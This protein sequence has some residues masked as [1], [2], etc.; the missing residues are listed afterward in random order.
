MLSIPSAGPFVPSCGWQEGATHTMRKQLGFMQL[1]IIVGYSLFYALYLITFFGLFASVPAG[2]DFTACH[3]GQLIYFGASVISMYAVLA[4][5]R[6][7]GSSTL[8]L[9]R[10][11]F[12][13]ALI[14]LAAPLPACFILH[15]IG[16]WVP[17]LALYA[18]CACSGVFTCLGFVLW[19]DLM[20]R[21]YMGGSGFLHSIVFA[22]GGMVFVAC[23]LAGSQAV[24]GTLCLVFLLAS[25]FLAAFISKR[26]EAS[27]DLPVQGAVEHFKSAFHL[28]VL[29]CATTLPFGFA[30]IL[31]Y[32]RLGV[33]IVV[34]M[35]LAV[36][37]DFALNMLIGAHRVVPFM[38]TL[39]TCVAF[40]TVALLLFTMPSDPAKVV[41]LGIVVCAWFV[42]RTVNGS[43]LMNLAA[44]K[45]V[46]LQYC[47]GRGKLAGN[48]GF[49]LGL[50][51]GIVTVQLMPAHPAAGGYIA[52]AIVACMVLAALFLLPF[53]NESEAPGIR[54][55]V[56]VEKSDLEFPEEVDLARKCQ[57]LIDRYKL[58]PRESEVL[59]YIV[60]GRNARHVAERLCISESTAKTH[61]SN[62]YRKTNVHSQQEL[63]D[64]IEE[65]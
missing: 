34:I 20:V 14:A 50:A 21:G 23:M 41:A 25:A 56:P 47:V 43:S 19:D 53:D 44:S 22:V 24:I 55:L 39:R 61:I 54:T 7:R 29:T 37:I 5:F 12:L 2:M 45:K 38:G 16:A 3:M 27:R 15:D 58:S 52:L 11:S 48:I 63:L 17:L 1:S 18:A 4:W 64:I 49:I 60:K 65:L 30:F 8:Q 59:G 9:N 40:S 13:V 33:G 28:D 36:A 26:A 31:L 42:Y 35:L 6:K 51:V 46:S 62:I 10:V 57:A 32:E